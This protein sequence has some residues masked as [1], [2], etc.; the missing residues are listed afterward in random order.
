MSA[1]V[2]GNDNL[3]RCEKK[4]KTTV[5]VPLWS[6]SSERS[7]RAKAPSYEKI[8]RIVNLNV[9]VSRVDDLYIHLCRV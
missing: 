8:M 1:I 9:G 6:G 4:C 2:T 7:N 5:L 3:H